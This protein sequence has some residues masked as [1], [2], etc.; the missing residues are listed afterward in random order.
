LFHCSHVIKLDNMSQRRLRGGAFLPIGVGCF[1]GFASMRSWKSLQRRRATCF[2][3]SGTGPS[4]FS[5]MCKRT[6]NCSLPIQ[7]SK[8]RVAVV[9]THRDFLLGNEIVD[10]LAPV[11]S[12]VE[13]RNQDPGHSSGHACTTAVS[14]AICV[15]KVERQGGRARPSRLRAPNHW[16]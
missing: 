1:L 7:Y 4:C 2:S 15:E 13:L 9:G 5:K 16:P 10:R 3:T 12:P 8:Q 14:A 6:T 11:S